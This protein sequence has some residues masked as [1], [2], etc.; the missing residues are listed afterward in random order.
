MESISVSRLI[1]ALGRSLPH[2]SKQHDEEEDKE[3]FETSF[4]SKFPG[5]NE[6]TLLK[7]IRLFIDRVEGNVRTLSGNVQ[8]T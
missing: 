3:L 1:V 5:P 2:P 7:N 4:A 6:E 8:S